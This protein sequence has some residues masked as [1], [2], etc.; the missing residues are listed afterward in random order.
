MTGGATIASNNCWFSCV[1]MLSLTIVQS[2]EIQY[3]GGMWIDST[4]GGLGIAG[5]Q[6]KQLL[7][8]NGVEG[9]RAMLSCACLSTQS[10]ERYD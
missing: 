9:L 3:V 1:C 8:H 7:K 4:L 2:L 10:L 6:R 5:E